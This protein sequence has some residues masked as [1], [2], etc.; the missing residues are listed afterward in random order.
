MFIHHYFVAKEHCVETKQ[1]ERLFRL[2][3]SLDTV[4]ILKII[5]WYGCE[6]VVM[7]SLGNPSC[8][9]RADLFISQ[10][11]VSP[12]PSSCRTCLENPG[13]PPCHH[14]THTHALMHAHTYRDYFIC[15]YKNYKVLSDLLS[16]R[17]VI[18]QM[19]PVP[20]S[21]PLK[22]WKMFLFL[23]MT[24]SPSNYRHQH[25]FW[26]ASSFM[27]LQKLRKILMI[28]KGFKEEFPLL[29]FDDLRFLLSPHLFGTR[30]SFSNCSVMDLAFCPSLQ[31]HFCSMCF[32]LSPPIISCQT[33]WSL[34]ILGNMH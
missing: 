6:K 15:I 9:H 34:F 1:Q 31:R 5:F 20:L 30:Y 27:L 24:Q 25:A 29:W 28:L 21:S 17:F 19:A 13:K 12:F 2:K 22:R 8:M 16:Q 11:T 18:T 23:S 10:G 33:F 14:N 4:H 7:K 26:S 32:M 3:V